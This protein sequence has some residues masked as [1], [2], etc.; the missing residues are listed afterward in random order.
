M[1]LAASGRPDP[2]GPLAQGVDRRVFRLAARRRRAQ[3]RALACGVV[4]LWSLVLCADVCAQVA[5]KKYQALYRDLD[6]FLRDE[7]GD[8]EL[9]FAPKF[10]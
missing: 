6:A 7:G 5:P 2:A 10:Q 3:K 4:A 9:A 8:S 1:P